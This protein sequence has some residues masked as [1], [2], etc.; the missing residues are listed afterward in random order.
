[1]VVHL[2]T[3]EGSN[4]SNTQREPG[5]ASRTPLPMPTAWEPCPGKVNAAVMDGPERPK[6]PK[7]A[8]KDTAGAGYV[9]PPPVPG[10]PIQSLSLAIALKIRIKPAIRGSRPGA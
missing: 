1:M 9:K 7:V 6:T 2:S 4:S 10:R 5:K 8:P 3:G